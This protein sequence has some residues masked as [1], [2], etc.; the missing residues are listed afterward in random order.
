MYIKIICKVLQYIEDQD[1]IIIEEMQKEVE[2]FI[3]DKECIKIKW[4]QTTAVVHEIRFGN[5][6]FAF[7]HLTA[8]IQWKPRTE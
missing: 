4:L 6:G 7:T 3:K 8:I 2:N 1:F 5:K